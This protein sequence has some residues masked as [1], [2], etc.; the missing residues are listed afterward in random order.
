MFGSAYALPVDAM[1]VARAAR[2]KI[3]ALSFM[4]ISSVPYQKRIANAPRLALGNSQYLARSASER[5][6]AGEKFQPTSEASLEIF[7]LVEEAQ[8][9]VDAGEVDAADG[10]QP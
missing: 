7:D 3:A 4:S 1:S 5:N 2:P 9:D 8:D 10:R 6:G